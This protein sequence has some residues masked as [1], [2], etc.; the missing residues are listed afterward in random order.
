VTALALRE[1]RRDGRMARIRE[2]VLTL[3]FAAVAA[4]TGYAFAISPR[5]GYATGGLFLLAWLAIAWRTAVLI[6]LMFACV[7]GFLKLWH[8]SPT[9][10]L[11][12]DV[13]LLAI[14]LGMLAS[15]SRTNWVRDTL[16]NTRGRP[17][18]F[19]I[20]VMTGML[21]NPGIGIV[22]ALAGFRERVLFTALFFVGAVYFD[23]WKRVARTM[24]VLI[25]GVTFA[26]VVA[27]V[28]IAVGD[29]WRQLGPGFAHASGKNQSFAYTQSAGQAR[30]LFS[31]AYGTLSDPAALGLAS[32]Y[33]IVLACAALPWTRGRARM[34]LAGALICMTLALLL[35]GSR[36]GMLTA[37][38]GFVT[39]VI[40]F[41]RR[42]D[43]RR[44]ARMAILILLI[45][46]SAGVAVTA[47][48]NVARYNSTTA[49]TEAGYRFTNVSEALTRLATRPFGAGLGSTG[50]GGRYRAAA[51]DT[52]RGL[53]N[54]VFAY[55]YEVGPLGFL[56][57]WGAQL[58]ILALTFKRA[59]GATSLQLRSVYNGLAAAQLGLFANGLL[60]QGSFDY[61]PI[62]QA[63]WLF[64]GSIIV[65]LQRL[66]APREQ[67]VPCRS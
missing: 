58:W 1:A 33:C 40:A 63:F 6:L 66:E 53:D 24:Y 67:A 54:V 31:R 62:A 25:G 52:L 42:L 8:G 43:T 30:E 10:Y 21:A 18:L 41:A 50:A 2:I 4:L 65:P 47:R 22:P 27:I 60:S 5:I 14:V 49:V 23:S 13:M 46:A 9:M 64:S 16:R 12:K 57:F 44:Y 45:G 29:A 32:G 55:L 39:L 36:S 17:V 20:V 48:A 35:S 7:D 11:V 38:V 26:S 59:R 3:A 19:Y 15:L 61:A 34:L 28:Q 56:A 37:S 51:G